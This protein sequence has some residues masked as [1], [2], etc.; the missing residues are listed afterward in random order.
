MKQPW[1]AVVNDPLPIDF[2]VWTWVSG[3]VSAPCLCLLSALCAALGTACMSKW[4]LPATYFAGPGR[5]GSVLQVALGLYRSYLPQWGAVGTSK[6]GQSNEVAFGENIPGSSG[7]LCSLRGGT[8]G[9]EVVTLLQQLTPAVVLSPRHPVGRGSTQHHRGPASMEQPL[10]SEAEAGGAKQGASGVL[11]CS[12]SPPLLG[13]VSGKRGPGASPIF[14]FWQLAPT[15]PACGSLSRQLAA[16]GCPEM[17]LHVL[18]EVLMPSASSSAP[19]ATGGWF[20]SLVLPPEDPLIFLTCTP[21]FPC[22]LDHPRFPRVT[23]GQFS[24]VWTRACEWCCT[25]SLCPPGK[26]ASA[27]QQ[28]AWAAAQHRSCER[29]R[30]SKSRAGS[31]W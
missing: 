24:V 14:P 4:F 20:G 22:Y 26:H 1:D 2:W 23:Q 9:Q 28:G 27:T 25:V 21:K 31:G 11:C 29:S 5:I 6:S 15:S 17:P 7:F 3:D 19:N 18:M 10:H 16:L 13:Q 8:P 12:P 30:C